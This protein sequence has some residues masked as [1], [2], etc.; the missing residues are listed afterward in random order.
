MKE[1]NESYI[2]ACMQIA[3][4]LLENE[5]FISKKMIQE[6][7]K[8]TSAENHLTK[9][10]KNE[11]ILKHIP[12]ESL[13]RKA[14]L[15][16][17]VKT[18]SGV[19]VIAVMPKPYDCPHG[20]CIYCPGGKEFNTPL[21]YI[22]TEPSTRIAQK[23]DYDPYMQVK[24]KLKQIE[25][26]GHDTDKIELVIVGGT[27]P[28]M[29]RDYQMN[30]VKSCYDALNDIKSTKLMTAISINEIA[31]KRCVGFTVETKPD[32]CKK[33]HIQLMLEMGITR[34]ELGIQ[35]LREDVYKLVNRGHTLNDVI[36][37]FQLLKDAGYKIVAHM[38]PGLPGSSLEKDLEDFKRL[39]DDPLF[40]PDM[41]KIYPTLAIKNTGLFKLFNEGKYIPYTESEL[42]NLLVE[43]KK[44]VPPWIRIMRIQR[45][46]E[47][48][49]IITG[50]KQ[51]N[52]RQRLAIVLKEKG[53]SCKCIR[54]REVGLIKQYPIEEN[55]YLKR[56]TYE[57]SHG[58]EIF[59]SYETQNE[60]LVTGF[61]RLRIPDIGERAFVRE[62]HIYGKLLNLG[63]KTKD[64]S[65]QHRGYGMRLL[66][67]A[68]RISF[69]EFDTK[70]LSIISAVG[71][72][73]YYR[74][75]GY[76]DDKYYVTKEF[77]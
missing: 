72:R 55:V 3:N 26:R 24:S 76:N 20:R 10:P 56:R 19:A 74:R 35:T 67:E 71:T 61:L 45:E 15:V 44:I 73:Q 14:L 28:F 23:Y 8:K 51:G 6:T 34:V 64:D 4:R 9:I 17:P 49:D 43:V 70:K 59:L 32:Y 50:P 69:E 47:P 37:S 60:S 11:H 52:L 2:N 54:C 22:G 58:K 66:E 39:F 31:K 48:N 57:A 5:V 13:I 53:F 41:L 46:I 12:S 1:N 62:L 18:S 68:E 27:F 77:G 36:E 65:F 33:D 25:E 30:F 40:R 21:S 16:K 38:M 42:I 63:R 75:R 7:I 29:P